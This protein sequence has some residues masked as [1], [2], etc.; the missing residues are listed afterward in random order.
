[1]ALSDLSKHG[2]EEPPG[3]EMVKRDSGIQGRPERVLHALRGL[4][5][6]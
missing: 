2:M 1:M 3:V 5:V 4:P 6:V